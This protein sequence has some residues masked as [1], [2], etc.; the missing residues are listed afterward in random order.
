MTNVTSAQL[1]SQQTEWIADHIQTEAN[2][3]NI[4]FVSHLGDVVS[5]A[6]DMVEWQRADLSMDRLDGIVKYSVLPGNHDYLLTST[7]NSGTENYLSYFGPSRFSSQS[8]FGGADPSGNNSYQL[9]NAGGFDFLHLAL[10][11]NPTDNTPL[12]QLSPL[13]WAQSVLDANPNLPVILSTHEYVQEEPPGRSVTGEELWNQ[14]ITKNDQIFMV[15]NGHFHR[16]GKP[17]GGQHHQVSTNDAGRSVVEVLQNYQGFPTGGEGWLRLIDFDIPNDRLRFETYSPFLDE[18]LETEPAQ[19]GTFAAQFELSIDFSTRLVPI[20]TSPQIPGDF[21]LDQ[22]VD[23]AD[24]LVWQNETTNGSLGD[25][26]LLDWKEHYG[27][28]AGDT[29]GPNLIPEPMTLQCLVWGFVL[30]MIGWPS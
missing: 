2:P 12:R 13:D 14:L 9:F 5:N 6:A 27:H 7:K 4:Q 24:F 23:G 28:G 18:F 25:S 8:W 1:F 30:F 19:F 26:D 15:L 21:N 17:F 20:L 10:E 3:R 22:S 29:L 11:W 16:F